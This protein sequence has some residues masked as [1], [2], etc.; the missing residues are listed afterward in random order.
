MIFLADMHSLLP[1]G[2]PLNCTACWS[3]W[4]LDACTEYVMS[5]EYLGYSED[6]TTTRKPRCAIVFGPVFTL[7]ATF[8]SSRE[9]GTDVATRA[10][11]STEFIMTHSDVPSAR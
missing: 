11:Q 8:S 1:E 3:C 7:A 2:C 4:Q 9:A 10:T 5:I 6:R